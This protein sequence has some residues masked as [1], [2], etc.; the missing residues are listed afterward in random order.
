MSFYDAHDE[1]RLAACL[2]VIAEN[3]KIKQKALA[4]KHHVRTIS[5][6]AG[7][8]TSLISELKRALTKG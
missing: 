4:R 2:K 5:L 1:E 7:F 3:P 8:D 6:D